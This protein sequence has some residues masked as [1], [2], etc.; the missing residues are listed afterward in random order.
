VDWDLVLSK[1]I[2][3]PFKPWLNRSN[4]DPEYTSM[5]PILDDEDPLVPLDDDK[6]GAPAINEFLTDFENR[7]AK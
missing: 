6:N 7:I 3:P 5:N 2:E 4:F 1:S